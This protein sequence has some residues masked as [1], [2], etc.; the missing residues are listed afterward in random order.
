MKWTEIC[1]CCI[2]AVTVFGQEFFIFCVTGCD[3]AQNLPQLF[4]SFILWCVGPPVVLLIFVHR[5]VLGLPYEVTFIWGRWD[6]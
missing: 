6:Y 1:E 4:N 2:L 5:T 3:P